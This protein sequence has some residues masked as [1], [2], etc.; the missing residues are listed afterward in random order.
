MEAAAAAAP[1][2]NK[3]KGSPLPL[4]LVENKKLSAKHAVYLDYLI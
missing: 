2:I 3:V 1:R 4:T